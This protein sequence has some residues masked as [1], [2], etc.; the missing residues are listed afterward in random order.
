MVSSQ[1]AAHG[2]DVAFPG[3]D[4]PLAIL[5]SASPDVRVVLPAQPK[6]YSRLSWLQVF[7]ACLSFSIHITLKQ[8][9]AEES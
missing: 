6:K 4:D 2:P 8:E 9:N 3:L 7:L 1:P 5:G